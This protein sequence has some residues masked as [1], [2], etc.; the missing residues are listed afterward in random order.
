[1]SYVSR[2]LKS[3]AGRHSSS[4]A[5]QLEQ[6]LE[7]S[8]VECRHTAKSKLEGD[9]FYSQS[10]PAECASSISLSTTA[11]FPRRQLKPGVQMPKIMRDIPDS[12]YHSKISAASA[13]RPKNF[14]GFGP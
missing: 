5:R 7:R 1:M 6:N 8:H 14:P 11:A 12:S 4:Q 2:G 13:K 3:M 10:L 9:A